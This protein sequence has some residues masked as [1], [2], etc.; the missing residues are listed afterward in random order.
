[1]GLL[2]ALGKLVEWFVNFLPR[3]YIVRSTHGAVLYVRGKATAV[4]PGTFVIYW[5]FWTETE[6]Y[7]V[8]IQT[9]RIESQSLLTEEGKPFAIKAVVRY[10]I[11]DHLAALT[12]LQDI[13]E[14]I[15]D[16][17]LGVFKLLAYGRNESYLIKNAAHI[18]DGAEDLLDG[19][20]EPFG[21]KVEEAY[22]SDLTFPSIHKLM[23]TK[24]DFG[25]QHES[26]G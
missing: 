4:Q 16:K 14:F 19:M 15:A 20:L 8:T 17:A 22:L 25:R 11:N 5:P 24:F 10:S 12:K 23:D 3:P 2:D 13:D 9:A 21:I 7:P 1:M 18:D 6:Q 26:I